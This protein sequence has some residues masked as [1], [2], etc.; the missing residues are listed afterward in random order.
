ML[1]CGISSRKHPPIFFQD[2]KAGCFASSG[3]VENVNLQPVVMMATC[4]A[5]EFLLDCNSP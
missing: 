1:G 2:T 4:V 3:K 5:L